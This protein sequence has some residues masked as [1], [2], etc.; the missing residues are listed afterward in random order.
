CART[1]GAAT[2]TTNARQHGKTR[3]GGTG[4]PLSLEEVKAL[5]AARQVSWLPGLQR[6]RAARRPAFPACSRVATWDWLP[7]HSAGTAPAFDRLP[8]RPPDRGHHG[9]GLR[10]SGVRLLPPFP[11]VK[12]E[13]AARS[14]PPGP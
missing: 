5:C 14:C 7:G 8:S 13:A 11:A 9:G 1:T 4:S 6:T 3:D 2:R 10:L 12:G